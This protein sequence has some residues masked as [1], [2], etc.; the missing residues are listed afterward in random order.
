MNLPRGALL[1][2]KNGHLRAMK[3]ELAA[4]PA[5]RETRSVRAGAVKRPIFISTPLTTVHKF[6]N[7][8]STLAP[9]LSALY[10]P[11]TFQVF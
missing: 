8:Q 7:E 9:F 10:H 3:T 11:A 2:L 5:Q 4:S 1:M 6:A